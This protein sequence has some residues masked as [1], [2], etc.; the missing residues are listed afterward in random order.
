MWAYAAGTHVCTH[1]V[2]LKFE[3]P[4]L[5][6]EETT[7]QITDKATICEEESKL[8]I[9]HEQFVSAE[10]LHKGQRFHQPGKARS[11]AQVTQITTQ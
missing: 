9:N 3:G 5:K 2:L 1:T 4:T 10:K 6:M 8:P 11:G 7:A